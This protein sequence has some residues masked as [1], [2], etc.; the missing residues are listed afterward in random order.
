MYYNKQ[1]VAIIQEEYDDAII[2]KGYNYVSTI[3]KSKQGKMAVRI[4]AIDDGKRI[5][6]YLY[7]IQ[8][9]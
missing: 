7:L 9:S 2:K 6:K 1:F 3:Q 8:M 5:S 4:M